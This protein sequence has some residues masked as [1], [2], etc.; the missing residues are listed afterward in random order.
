MSHDYFSVSFDT[1]TEAVVGA[2]GASPARIDY[3]LAALRPKLA[4]LRSAPQREAAPLLALP[5]S[6][7]DLAEIEQ[8]AADIRADFSTLVVVGMGGSSLSGQVLS[9]LQQPGSM[10]VKFID[11]IDPQAFDTFCGSVDWKSTAFLVISKSGGTV[12]TL[13][14]F[15]VLLRH[16]KRQL[17]TSYAKHF[18]VITITNHNPLHTLAVEE[19]IPVLPHD[20]DLGGRF[21]IFSSVGLI[22]GAVMGLDIR[23]FREGAAAIIEANFNGSKPDAVEGAALHLALLEKQARQHVFLHYADKLGGYGLWFRQC[24][25][26]SLGKCASLTTPLLARGATDQHS[27]VQLFLDG[28]KDKYFTVMMC[29]WL[30]QG[31]AIDYPNNQDN[32]LAFLAGQ[33]LGDLMEAQQQATLDTLVQRGA[34]ARSIRVHTVNEAVTGALLMHTALEIMFSAV[35]MGID[36]FD[37]P[38]VED[39]KKLALKYLEAGQRSGAFSKSA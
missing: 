22:P 33:R 7:S 16:A 3:W 21:S 39:G 19:S 9:Y 12:E 17:P 26:E 32:R 27:Q 15:A 5:F 23:A 13:A 10:A 24:W 18:G 25:A 29:D 37:Q 8:I 30:G 31:E 38:A 28:P 14:Q 34:P 1:A 4:A 6:T 36:A 11:N 35:L 2:C 20:P